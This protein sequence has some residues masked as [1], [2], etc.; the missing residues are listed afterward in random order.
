MAPTLSEPLS[1]GGGGLGGCRSHME[2]GR[3]TLSGHGLINGVGSQDTSGAK[4][5][6]QHA[7]STHNSIVRACGGQKAQNT[8]TGASRFKLAQTS[9]GHI[10]YMGQGINKHPVNFFIDISNG[11]LLC[12]SKGKIRVKRRSAAH[13]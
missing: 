12:C 13:I 11:H 3:Q 4:G 9:G 8:G 5:V 7:S 6:F 10:R 1:V 2:A